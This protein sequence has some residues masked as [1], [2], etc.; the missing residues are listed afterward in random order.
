[1][2]FDCA[3]EVAREIAGYIPYRAP[4][5]AENQNTIDSGSIHQARKA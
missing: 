5:P 1:M 4:F 3:V 2:V